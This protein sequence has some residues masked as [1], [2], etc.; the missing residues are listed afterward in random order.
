MNGRDGYLGTAWQILALVRRI[1]ARAWWPLLA[2]VL[3]CGATS[4]IGPERWGPRAQGDMAGY[5]VYSYRQWQSTDLQLSPG[6][7]IRISARGEWQY[8]P[9]V[10]MHGPEGGLA[11]MP[12]YPLPGE[13]GGALVGRV[14][15][16]GDVFYVGR[17]TALVVRDPGMLLLRINDDILSDNRGQLDVEIEVVREP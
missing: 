7:R 8:S 17:G 10:G 3:L 14:G 12:E 11:G 4:A 15:D 16:R 9:F 2:V 1:P 13:R 6:D 5:R